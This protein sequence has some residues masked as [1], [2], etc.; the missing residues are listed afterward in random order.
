M[1][2]PTFE[3]R[4]LADPFATYNYCELPAQP[5]IPIVPGPPVHWVAVL[6]TMRRVGEAFRLGLKAEDKWGNP[7]DTVD[8]VLRLEPSIPVEGLP[9]AL[10]RFAGFEQCGLWLRAA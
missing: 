5:F 6:P 10:G 4:V 1:A 9:E 7:S 2:E 8:Q 3:F